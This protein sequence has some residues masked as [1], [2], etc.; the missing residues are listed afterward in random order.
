MLNIDTGQIEPPFLSWEE[1]I[2][3][4]EDYQIENDDF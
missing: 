1:F 4:M 2:A 3:F